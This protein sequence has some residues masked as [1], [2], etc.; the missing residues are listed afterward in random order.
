LPSF[1][2]HELLDSERGEGLLVESGHGVELMG[3]QADVVEHG[4][5]P[6]ASG[7]E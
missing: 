5:G 2:G 4:I 7:G 6:L 3:A 1:E